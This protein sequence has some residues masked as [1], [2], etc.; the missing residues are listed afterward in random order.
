MNENVSDFYFKVAGIRYYRLTDNTVAVV[1][2]SDYSD[3]VIIPE[4][5]I[6]DNIK[7][8]VTKIGDHAFHDNYGF[9]RI[10]IP[11]T[12]T[13]IGDCAFLGC[14]VTSVV[15]PDSVTK[16]GQ[17]AFMD[18]IWLTSIIIPESV[19][20][21]GEE[22]FLGCSGLT[23]VIIPDSVTEIGDCAFDE[24]DGLT[25]I[26]V[27]SDNAVYCSVDGVLYSKDMKTLIVCPGGKQG[28]VEITDSV[29]KI[30]NCA[31]S[32]CRKLTSIKIPDS[33]TEIGESAFAYC[34][35]LTS[36]K[37]PDSVTKIGESALYGCDGLTSVKIPESVTKI[38]ELSCAR[39]SRLKNLCIGKNVR[40][41]ESRAFDDC[42]SIEE[43]EIT[44]VVP[45]AV[46]EN[47]YIFSTRV[48]ARAT[49]RVPEAAIESYRIAYPWRKF[50]T[51]KPLEK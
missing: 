2:G 24:C 46:D 32:E 39:C 20:E 45:P 16:I 10:S 23:S 19:T 41:I 8:S 44:A 42:A 12:V 48:Y 6:Y 17:A 37:I 29:T 50:L 25:S 47:D 18:C 11:D 40:E 38:G 9:T 21:I 22:A 27:D 1:G 15:M 49:L 33:V 28:S 5:V 36:I 4:S 51:I 30:Y 3:D 34:D 7:Y 35:G 13:E 26:D 43:I 14:D 31:F